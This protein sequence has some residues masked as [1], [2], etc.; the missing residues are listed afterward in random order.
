MLGLDQPLD[1]D[2]MDWVRRAASVRQRVL[3]HHGTRDWSS[4]LGSSEAF[5]TAAPVAEL[6][7][8]AGGHTT[9]WNVDPDAWRRATASFLSGR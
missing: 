1:L 4:P 5:A 6:V 2:E 9:G 7:T 8:S 3:I